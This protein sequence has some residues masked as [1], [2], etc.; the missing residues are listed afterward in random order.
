MHTVY[1]VDSRLNIF[2]KV[3]LRLLFYVFIKAIILLTVI[4][5]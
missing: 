1:I 2:S 3:F 4:I 5:S